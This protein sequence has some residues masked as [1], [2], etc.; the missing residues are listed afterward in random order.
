[1]FSF[2]KNLKNERDGDSMKI[3]T[4][5]KKDGDLCFTQV[6]EILFL[7]RIKNDDRLMKYYIKLLNNSYLDDEF[8]RVHNNFIDV[9]K[10]CEDII[11]FCDYIDCDVSYLSNYLVTMNCLT[12]V[13]DQ[14]AKE[15][16]IHKS[17]GIRD[18]MYFK[19]G[20]LDYLI[21]IVPNGEFEKFD[22]NNE[23][24]FDS[25]IIPDVFLLR[26]IDGRDVNTIDYDEFFKKCIDE[27]Y[28]SNYS[29]VNDDERNYE[30]KD[31]GNTFVLYIN[32]RPPKKIGKF[33][34]FIKKRLIKKH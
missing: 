16:L 22:L 33:E 8:V 11:N 31:R 24:V 28:K 10:S 23:L 29:Y 34:E 18:M 12:Y 25:S 17:D 7:A 14:C 13:N 4:T 27:V 1:M 20:E 5:T 9:V 15:C 6:K 32:N 30:Y 19:K 2:G 3:I 26:T 21:P